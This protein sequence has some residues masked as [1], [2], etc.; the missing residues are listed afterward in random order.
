M[1]L[2]SQYLRSLFHI[3]DRDE[4]QYCVWGLTAVWGYISKAVCLWPFNLLPFLSCCFFFLS[5]VGATMKFVMIY[6]LGMF[7][8]YLYMM[9]LSWTVFEM[10]TPIMGRSG[11]EILPDVV[12]AGFI[13][14]STV[15]LS[16][17]FVSRIFKC[18]LKL[19]KLFLEFRASSKNFSKNNA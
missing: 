10:F 9:Y 19:F 15:I 16:S 11:S 17:Y 5:S 8:P 6:M 18:C 3:H 7:V 13:V 2:H 12:L 1:L 14:V 4:D